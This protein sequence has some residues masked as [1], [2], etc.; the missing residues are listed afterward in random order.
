VRMRAGDCARQS[1]IASPLFLSEPIWQPGKPLPLLAKEATKNTVLSP[2]MLG[3]IQSDCAF[4][5]LLY[6]VCTP[7]HLISCISY[8]M[9]WTHFTYRP[10]PIDLSKCPG[11]TLRYSS[12]CV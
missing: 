11:K 7:N 2:L 1:L 6:K 9:S 8:Y 3:W 10:G 12:N 5:M 4:H